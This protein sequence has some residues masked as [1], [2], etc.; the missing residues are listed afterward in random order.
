MKNISMLLLFT[1]Y[2]THV[3]LTQ[4]KKK[5]CFA[6]FGVSGGSPVF[7]KGLWGG[8]VSQRGSVVSLSL[9]YLSEV[10]GAQFTVS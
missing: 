2:I 7:T 3:T 1:L 4:S 10:I 8:G 5:S 9:T 6:G